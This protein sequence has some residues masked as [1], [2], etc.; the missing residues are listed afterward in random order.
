MGVLFLMP[1]WNVLS[2][3]WMPRMLT[4]LESDLAVVVTRDPPASSTWRD[5]VP[6]VSLRQTA[7]VTRLDYW[8]HRLRL[9]ALPTNPS[10]PE[11]LLKEMRRPEVTRVLCHYAPFAARFMDV[12]RATSVPLFIHFHGY[13]ATFDRRGPDH[14]EKPYYDEEYLRALHELSARAIFIA[15]SKFTRSLLCAAG[16]PADRVRVNYLGVP[17]PPIGKAHT[18]REEV[19]ILHLGRL[20]DFKSPDRTIRAFEIARS[21]G[22][23]GQ[24]IIAGDGHLRVTCELL[25]VRSPYRESIHLLGAVPYDEAGRLLADADILTQHNVKGEISRQQECL[26]VSVLEGMAAGL[27]IVGTRSAGVLE[28]VVPDETGLLGE[29]QDIEAQANSFLRLA[30]DP[31]LRQRLGDAGRRRVAE[32]FSL[33]QSIAGLRAIMDLDADKQ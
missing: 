11:V 24:L 13:D 7:T 33:E 28:T 25:R 17:V 31:A 21:R 32:H 22:L 6:A 29:P 4:G 9:R 18:K 12:W 26:G 20:T 23:K 2:E 27:P 1:R 5:H 30:G 19:K 15:N 10:Q 16:M 3:G 14:A 8:L